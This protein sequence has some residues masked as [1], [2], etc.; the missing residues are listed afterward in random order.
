MNQY[1]VFA[2]F[3]TK[4]LIGFR[5]K[6]QELENELFE[7]N[8]Q[9]DL[10]VNHYFAEG[11]YAREL[12]IPAGTTLTGK[13]H[14]TE[15]LNILTKGK[16]TVV[17]DAGQSTIEAPHIMVSSPNT[18]RAGYAHTDSIWITVHGTHEK[19]LEKLENEL[20]TTEYLSIVGRSVE[21]N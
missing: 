3:E 18:K 4:G 9:I 19:D 1:D 13:I 8:N 12:I 6:I 5:N 17:S 21:D 2:G 16:I 10:E 7:S 14:K 20:I 15:H 11:I